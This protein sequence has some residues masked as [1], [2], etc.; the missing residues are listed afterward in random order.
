MRAGSSLP[1]RLYRRLLALYPP[2][3]RARYADEMAQLFEDQVRDARR[4]DARS[5]VARTIVRSVGDVVVTAIGEHARGTRSVAHSA[6]LAPAG[7][8]RALGL[9][10]VIGGLMLVATFLPNLQLSPELWTVRLVLFNVGAIAIVLAVHRRNVRV[11]RPLSLAAAV[12]AI[13]ANVWYLVMVVISTGRPQPPAG[14]PE[15]RLVMFAAGASMWLADAVF[16]LVTLRLRAAARLGAVALFAGSV[17]AIT[18]MDRLELV[19]GDA[20]WFFV[21]AALAGIALNGAGWILLG[22]DVAIRRST[23]GGRLVPVGTDPAG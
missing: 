2:A 3:F 22:L 17:L 19:S 4:E 9:A 11:S 12:P 10:G 18:G 8:T 15:F 14:D 16:G 1:L 23:G 6:D 21:P 5:G 20:A 13:V 7:W